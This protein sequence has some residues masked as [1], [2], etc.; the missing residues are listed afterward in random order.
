MRESVRIERPGSVFTSVSAAAPAWTAAAATSTRLA[1]PGE[2]FTQRGR[3]AAAAAATTSAVAM[4]ERAN[5]SRPS[6]R[7]GHDTL[8]STAMIESDAAAM[9]AAA[10]AYSS[11]RLPQMLTTTRAPAASRAGRSRASHAAT[12]GPWSPTLFSIPP[13]TGFK[14]GGGFPGQG[15]AESDFT[16]TA[17]S[18]ARSKYAASSA[19]WPEVPDAVITGFG[20]STEPIE[21]V[22]STLPRRVLIA[23][24]RGV[25]AG[26]S[27]SSRTVSIRRCPLPRPVPP[28]P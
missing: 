6:S 2:S 15:S 12:P 19:P 4:G 17:P 5:I 21:V 26:S 9:S 28:A 18:A 1:V 8:T 22:R 20:S 25:L 10:L 23:V 16:T 3:P 7:F 13:E 24:P 11:T 27:R 14:R